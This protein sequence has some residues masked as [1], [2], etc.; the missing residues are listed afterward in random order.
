MPELPEVRTVASIL[1]KEL[2]NQ[3]ITAI[4][5]IFPKVISKDSLDINLLINK[6]LKDIKTY[7]KYLLFDYDNYI[8]ISHLRMEGKYFIKNKNDSIEKHEHIIFIF[9]D[10]TSLRYHDTRKFGRI[11]LIK[12]GELSKNKSLSKLAL[13][14]FDIDI[15]DL[16]QKII[17]KKTPIKTI[18]LDQTIISGL[19]NIYANEVLYNSEINPFKLGKD[20]TFNEV[21]KIVNS[22]I[23][24]LNLAILNKGT[25][26]RSYMGALNVTGNY[27][28]YLKVHMKSGK[29]C[30]KCH[31][32]IIKVKINGRSTY[33]CEN[34]QK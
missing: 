15:N 8:L 11:E 22:A 25:T 7:G 9:N 17:K 27:Q 33:Y 21:K 18:L 16:Y 4:K 20:M 26:I 30:S 31:N 1:K 6:K 5:V 14:P 34:C 24:I 13:E 3:K 19:G 32:D 23:K 12:K 10:N 28:K 2:L 29:K